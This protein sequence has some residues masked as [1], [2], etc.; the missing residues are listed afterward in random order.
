MNTA[1]NPR[2]Q[3]QHPRNAC[4]ALLAT[5]LLTLLLVAAPA[6]AATASSSLQAAATR[7]LVAQ[8]NAEYRT[9]FPSHNS[10][11]AV[12]VRG[13]AAALRTYAGELPA[14]RGVGAQRTAGQLTG[15]LSKTKVA[16]QIWPLPE[17]V[18]GLSTRLGRQLGVTS[19][20]APHADGAAVASTEMSALVAAAAG[21]AAAH[22][23]GQA[24]AALAAA[25]ALFAQHSQ[26]RLDGVAPELVTQ[27]VRDLWSGVT[28]SG[29]GGPVHAAGLGG[30]VAQTRT[31]AQ[32][33]QRAIA[34]VQSDLH[35]DAAATGQVKVTR[36]T[37]VSDAAIILFREGLEAVLILAAITASFTGERRRLRRPVLIGA[38]FGLLATAVTYVLAQAI[39]DA[40]GD[41]G[42]RLQAI[43]G[44]IAIIVL[45]VVTNWFFHRVY[46]SEWIARFN[47]RRKALER[48]EQLGFISGQTLGFLMLGLT[49]VYREGFETVLFLQNLQVSAGTGATLLGV[50]IGLGATLIVGVITFALGRKL[51]YKRMLIV[52]GILIGLVLAVMVGTTVN[53]LQGL[54]WV[55]SSQMGFTVDLR[56][57]QWTGFYPTWEGMAAQLT[58]LMV[59]YGSYAVARQMQLY[60]RRRAVA[61]APVPA[62]A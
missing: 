28:A 11:A 27:T 1:S 41:G 36:A 35:D 31:Q 33:I 32:A 16:L 8:I 46:W 6:G 47:R 12:H 21:A 24:G 17:D 58:A 57:S 3:R 55:P 56:V 18:E 20:R 30:G 52:T 51:R 14:P 9:A 44:I 53:N 61:A 19:G 26:I 38:G 29:L 42:L 49:S 37:I 60:R 4:W 23:P 13:M 25:Y 34:R 43:T 39:V 59:V 48:V 50:A 40:L 10:A 54:G 45:L 2:A 5:A 15:V 22:Q 7:A 62:E